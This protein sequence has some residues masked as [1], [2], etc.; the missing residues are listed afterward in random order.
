MRRCEWRSSAR[1]FRAQ[2]DIGRRLDPRRGD[3]RR[4]SPSSP[5]PLNAGEREQ[6]EGPDRASLDQPHV[7]PTRE[8]VADDPPWEV[9]TPADLRAKTPPDPLFES[10]Q[11]RRLRADPTDHDDLPARP[12]HAHRFAERRRGS[13]VTVST[14]ISTAQLG[15]KEGIRVQVKHQS[16]RFP[17]RE[18]KL[19]S[20]S[21]PRSREACRGTP[22]RSNRPQRSRTVSAGR[23]A[24]LFPPPPPGRPRALL[25]GKPDR[26]F[27][28]GDEAQGH[29]RRRGEAQDVLVE[30]RTLPRSGRGVPAFKRQGGRRNQK[31]ILAQQGFSECRLVART[32]S[33]R[34]VCRGRNAGTSG[35]I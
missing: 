9:R 21:R 17:T 20:V 14:Y 3:I 11:N 13:G 23:L 32:R 35:L 33:A 29:H 1:R 18:S 6:A 22:A 10:D 34:T 27:L 24:S 26:T 19:G 7:L 5:R 2:A 25:P 8:P 31:P 28:V 12:D 30:L 15:Q 16:R 4:R